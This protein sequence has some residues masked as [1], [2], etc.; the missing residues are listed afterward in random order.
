VKD[1]ARVEMRSHSA[2]ERADMETLH[3]PPSPPQ[4][5][6]RDAGVPKSRMRGPHVRF[7]GRGPGETRGPYPTCAW[8]GHRAGGDWMT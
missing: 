1:E 3:L 5:G 4:L 8:H 2:T 7:R 6:S